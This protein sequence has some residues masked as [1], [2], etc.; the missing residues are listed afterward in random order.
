MI[1]FHWTFCN[2]W[3]HDIST[4]FQHFCSF[5][6]L[7]WNSYISWFWSNLSK[8][9]NSVFE[10]LGFFHIFYKHFF[11]LNVPSLLSDKCKILR[12]FLY[13]LP[14]GCTLRCHVRVVMALVWQG[15]IVFKDYAFCWTNRRINNVKLLCFNI[16]IIFARRGNFW[17][18]FELS[19]LRIAHFRRNRIRHFR[20]FGHNWR[21][22][23]WPLRI[24]PHLIKM[25]HQKLRA[26]LKITSRQP[27][28]ISKW[29]FLVFDHLII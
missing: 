1:T 26:F 27:Y 5:Y 20:H 16:F 9:Q 2:I 22:S 29:F 19:C 14:Y 15:H 23:H 8:M 10:I 17:A 3:G 25:V 24:S 4:F 11:F 12:W 7:R 13:F 28:W 21:S 18:L 6:L